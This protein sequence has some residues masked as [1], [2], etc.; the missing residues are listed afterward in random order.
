M[1]GKGRWADSHLH[2]RLVLRLQQP[3]GPRALARDVKI[4]I[5]ALVVLHGS[6][7]REERRGV[8]TACL[9]ARNLF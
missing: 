9:R 5:V 2:G 8:S 3:V 6:V 4:D 7:K 1:D